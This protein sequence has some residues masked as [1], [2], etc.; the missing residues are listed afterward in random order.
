MAGLVY[1]NDKEYHI[2][3]GTGDVGRY[4]I[5]PGDPGRCEKI[6]K[7]L[8]NAVFV[9]QNREYTSYTG[10]LN[11]EKVSVVSTGIGGPSATIA[12]EELVHIGAD[13]FI[14]VGTSGGMNENVLS[15][16]IVIATGAVRQEGTSCEYAPIEYP[17]VA[18]FSVV[19]ALN[20]AAEKLNLRY[21]TGVVQSK[22]SFYGEHSPETMPAGKKLLYDWDAWIKCGALTSEMETAALFIASS[23]RRVRIGAVLTVMGNQTR[24][25]MG[26]E[27][28]ICYDSSDAIKTA[29]EAMKILIENDKRKAGCK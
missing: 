27:D 2:K 17:A 5:L 6:A 24:R 10:Y 9:A 16:D 8:D 13:T 1:S 7:Y 25:D 20:F 19:T 26:Y 14:R 29:V 12:L 11:G 22:D 21:H 4:V 18:D 28:K 15:G 23:V 3:L